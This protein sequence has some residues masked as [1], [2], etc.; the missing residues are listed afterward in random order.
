VLHAPSDEKFAERF[1]TLPNDLIVQADRYGV[2]LRALDLRT[3]SQ[4]GTFADQIRAEL[5]RLALLGHVPDRPA[6][7]A[8]A[9]PDSA[10]WHG[11]S[12]M[13]SVH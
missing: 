11:Q 8:Q 10:D 6:W 5:R 13:G 3:R 12:Y 4:E 1:N 2:D 9:P 7:P